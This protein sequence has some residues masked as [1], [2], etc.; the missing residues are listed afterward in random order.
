MLLFEQKEEN[1]VKGQCNVVDI[2]SLLGHPSNAYQKFYYNNIS[3]PLPK[4]DIFK[5]K[6]S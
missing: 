6:G 4:L 2:N 1:I 5:V 3:P